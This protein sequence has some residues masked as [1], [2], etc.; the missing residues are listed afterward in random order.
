MKIVNLEDL[1]EHGMVITSIDISDAEVVDIR[2]VDEN[3]LIRAQIVF[4]RGVG[5]YN[6]D[7]WIIG[8]AK[9]LRVTFDDGTTAVFTNLMVDE[10]YGNPDNV[11]AT[12]EQLKR[13]VFGN[14]ERT[15]E[16]ETDM[17]DIF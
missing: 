6:R 5:V 11:N 15:E 14:D 7:C 3:D 13:L 1:N 12:V 8:C 17:P 4:N 10:V 16:P 9:G 2:T